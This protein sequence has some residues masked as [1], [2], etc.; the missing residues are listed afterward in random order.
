MVLFGHTNLEL[1]FYLMRIRNVKISLYASLIFSAT[2]SVGVRS[3]INA[4]F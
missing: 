3:V 1:I 2:L 4:E